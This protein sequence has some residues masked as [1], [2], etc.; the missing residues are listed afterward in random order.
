MWKHT[1]SSVRINSLLSWHAFP[2]SLHAQAGWAAVKGESGMDC[3]LPHSSECV[4]SAAV[5]C[6][7]LLEADHLRPLKVS[8]NM[9][10]QA[11]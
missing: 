1:C 8:A 11:Q 5:T 6:T 10:L 7:L 2:A 3:M 9:L 4:D